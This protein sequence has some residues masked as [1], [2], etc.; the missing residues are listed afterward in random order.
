MLLQVHK[1]HRLQ[2]NAPRPRFNLDNTPF[3]ACAVVSRASSTLPPQSRHELK[4]IRQCTCPNCLPHAS[5][6]LLLLLLEFFCQAESR[7]L[8]RD[9][10][11]RRDEDS[12]QGTGRRRQPAQLMEPDMQDVLLE[13]Q[14][15]E[16]LDQQQVPLSL[17]VPANTSAALHAT[18]LSQS[19]QKSEAGGTCSQARRQLPRTDTLD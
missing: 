11:Q 5:I 4:L 1:R 10:T 8:S 6:C 13:L 14:G 9:L 18:C 3:G 15:L 7:T 16:C 12:L 19:R 17:L 2:P